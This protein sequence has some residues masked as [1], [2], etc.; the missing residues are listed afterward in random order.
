M[1]ST[2]VRRKPCPPHFPY[3]LAA[4]RSPWSHDPERSPRPP[5][6]HDEEG[7]RAGGGGRPL[8]SRLPAPVDEQGCHLR[9]RISRRI[10]HPDIVCASVAGQ[11]GKAIGSRSDRPCRMPRTSNLGH[12]AR[13]PDSSM[14][15]YRS[16][17]PRHS[18][19]CAVAKSSRSPTAG[20]G[21]TPGPTSRHIRASRRRALALRFSRYPP[22]RMRTNQL[23][24]ASARRRAFS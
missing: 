8:Q 22:G 23:A 5:C 18:E 2:S 17:R 3:R 15:G 14:P 7:R 10:F 13:R 6:R 21:N 9:A 11:I 19:C 16:T 1:P 12:G 4:G 20:G 24:S